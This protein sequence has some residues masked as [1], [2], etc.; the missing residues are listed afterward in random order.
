[1]RIAFLYT[2]TRAA[3]RRCDGR[4]Q[5]RKC[6]SNFFVRLLVRRY[7]IDALALPLVCFA[8]HS[9]SRSVFFHEQRTL[10]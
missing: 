5:K 3:D 9:G 8:P 1:M 10:W 6:D 2:S 7:R 4:H